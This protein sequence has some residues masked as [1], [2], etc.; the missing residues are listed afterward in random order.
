MKA[1]S[2]P[3]RPPFQASTVDLFAAFSRGRKFSIKTLIVSY[4]FH[5][6]QKVRSFSFSPLI[7]ITSVR[8]KI[9]F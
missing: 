6:F 3:A 1:A 5:T 2:F 9:R 4:E 7:S 8:A